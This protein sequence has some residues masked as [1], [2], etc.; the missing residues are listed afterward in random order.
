M[1]A[2]S[3]GSGIA[4]CKS[5]N[6]R[7]TYVEGVR[8]KHR[9]VIVLQHMAITPTTSISFFRDHHFPF[10]GAGTPFFHEQSTRP[11]LYEYRNS[12]A[13]SC[14]HQSPPITSATAPSDR[15]LKAR[16]QACRNERNIVVSP[17]NP[18]HGESA[19]GDDSWMLP[20]LLRN[21]AGTALDY[22]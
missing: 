10:I 22:R 2:H 3:S 1:S 13:F 6:H 14:P 15:S 20:L 4:R 8:D 18:R 17:C 12:R 9:A 21:T 7:D 16:C 19:N 5:S 11:L